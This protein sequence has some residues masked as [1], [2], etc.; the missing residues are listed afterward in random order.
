GQRLGGRLGRVPQDR[1]SGERAAE[2]AMTDQEFYDRVNRAVG[3]LTR[4]PGGPPP[5]R[6]EVDRASGAL[7]EL[8]ED[9]GTAGDRDGPAALHAAYA[10]LGRVS[11]LL[12]PDP[13]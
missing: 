1:G 4:D 8:R 7:A 13:G 3:G 10:L 5:G 12:E 9:P 11:A 6:D 2:A